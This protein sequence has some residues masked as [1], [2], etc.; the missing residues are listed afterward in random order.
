[1]VL[2]RFQICGLK[3]LIRAKD[4]IQEDALYDEIIEIIEVI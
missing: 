2:R 1:M 4:P 3:K